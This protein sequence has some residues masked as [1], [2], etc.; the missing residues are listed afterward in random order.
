MG[1]FSAF[2]ISCGGGGGG[3][4]PNPASSGLKIFASSRVH[5]GDFLGD[6]GLTG[7]TAMEKA[8]NFCQTDPAKP[9]SATYKA[10]LV[11]GMTRDALVPLDWVLKPNTAYYQAQGNVRIMTTTSTAIFPTNLEHDIHDSFGTS[12][13]PNNPAPTSTVWTGFIDGYSFTA[14]TQTCSGWTYRDNG[15]DSPYGI[16]YGTDGTE[17]YTNGGQ[18]CSLESRV[19]CVQQ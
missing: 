8:D 1:F 18:V 13:D 11:D 10:M 17:L 5:N 19:Y 3:S 4:N 14:N 6:T 15:Q 12:S 16:S 9:D 7:Q 2:L